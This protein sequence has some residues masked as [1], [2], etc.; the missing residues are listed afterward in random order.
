MGARIAVRQCASS[1]HN[2]ASLI[3]IHTNERSRLH[4][5]KSA[6]LLKR[7]SKSG[8]EQRSNIEEFNILSSYKECPDHLQVLE[9]QPSWSIII[10][11]MSIM[12]PTG[13]ISAVGAQARDAMANQ[14][15]KELAHGAHVTTVPHSMYQPADQGVHQRQAELLHEAG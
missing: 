12:Q 7:G 9:T 2:K 1:L 14:Q 3:T 8:Q 4:A 6:D 5:I 11:K 15:A 13:R 10:H